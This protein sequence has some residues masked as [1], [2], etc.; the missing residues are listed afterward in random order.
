M[1]KKKSLL[2]SSLK[3][4]AFSGATAVFIKS[5]NHPKANAK[6]GLIDWKVARKTA[7]SK[8]IVDSRLLTQNAQLQTEYEKIAGDLAPLIAN[9]CQDT[10]WFVPP[11]KIVDCQ[12]WVLV[13]LS[14][15]ERLLKPLEGKASQTPSS[16]DI[17]V[18][19]LTSRYIGELFSLLSKRALGQF[20]PVL[21]LPGSLEPLT[22]PFLYI[23]DPNILSFS[24][25]QNIPVEPLRR[26]VV[27]HELCHAWQFGANPWLITYIGSLIEDLIKT[28]LESQKTSIN[29]NTLLEL[30][31][32][33]RERFIKV[34]KIQAVMSILEGHANF[35]MKR[36]GQNNIDQFDT[37]SLAFQKRTQNN[38]LLD[39]LIFI[40]SGIAPKLRQYVVGEKFLREVYASGGDPLLNIVW[41]GPEML[42]S[43]KELKNPS[44]W[45]QR[46]TSL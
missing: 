40:F 2:R 30:P 17:G 20:D 45:I 23:V 31:Q 35:I 25:K 9:E 16:L 5:L 38:T 39:R 18:R 8:T 27:S 21:R 3:L 32:Q 29:P 1:N 15:A 14:L 44:L 34:G 4:A 33:I 36:V 6:P 10:S 46:I 37:I 43:P 13:N 7:Y 42:P 28:N 12:E 22:V 19:N 11:V 26:W 24:K 41:E